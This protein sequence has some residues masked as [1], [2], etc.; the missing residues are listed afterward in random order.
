VQ[1]LDA[2]RAAKQA[3]IPVYTI[4]LGTPEGT[5]ELPG[6]QLG[7]RQALTRRVNVPPDDET[8]KQIAQITGGQFFSAPTANDLRA[9]Y[10]DIGSRIGFE[11][12]HQEATFAFAAAGTVLFVAG[13]ALALAWSYRFP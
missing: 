11:Y 1:P 9:V 4:A 7:G 3:G 8:L 6:P 2:A 5:L 12:E 13:A 10:Q